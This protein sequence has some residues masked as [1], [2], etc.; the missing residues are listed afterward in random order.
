MYNEENG[1]SVT[2]TLIYGVQWDAIMRWMKDVPNLTGGKY[3]QD[4]TGMGWHSD[5]YASGNPNRTTGID[6][7]EGKNKVK[8]IYDLAVNVIEWT[9]ESYYTLVRVNQGGLCSSSGSYNP[10]SYRNYDYPSYR[11]SYIG[12]CR[13]SE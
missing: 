13:L 8:N 2:S 11:G 1:D 3:V 7:D 10:A 4:S 5:N 6:L 9:M 12:F